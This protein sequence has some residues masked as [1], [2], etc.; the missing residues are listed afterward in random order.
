MCKINKCWRVRRELKI[1]FSF[2]TVMIFISCTIS[3]FGGRWIHIFRSIWAFVRMSSRIE[4][5]RSIVFLVVYECCEKR[6][7]KLISVT[8][9][10]LLL[11]DLFL[12]LSHSSEVLR[13]ESRT[14]SVC[15]SLE[16]LLSF[17]ICHEH[18]LVEPRF[19][20]VTRLPIRDGF[21]EMRLRKH[22]SNSNISQQCRSF[23]MVTKCSRSCL[24][25]QYYHRLCFSVLMCQRLG[26][27]GMLLQ[28]K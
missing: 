11:K 28:I 16:Q 4:L 20:L 8:I 9:L 5:F 3:I 7:E 13:N 18:V 12:W 21:S 22:L 26:L 2:E 6:S 1:S 19:L 15:E 17:I 25:F 14:Q 27:P 23:F 10:K 24:A